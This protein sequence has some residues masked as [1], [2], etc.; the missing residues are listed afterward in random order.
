MCHTHSTIEWLL[1]IDWLVLAHAFAAVV[2]TTPVTAAD[3][4]SRL[5]YPYIGIRSQCS[6]CLDYNIIIIMIEMDVRCA[7]THNKKKMCAKR[8]TVCASISLLLFNVYVHHTHNGS[9]YEILAPRL[10]V[11][12]G[13]GYRSFEITNVGTTRCPF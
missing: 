10:S 8:D 1:G 6:N 9:R 12:K 2:K 7:A 4:A 3:S 5:A 11:E 13:A